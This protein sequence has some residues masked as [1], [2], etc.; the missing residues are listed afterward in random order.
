MA[1]VPPPAG[2][3]RP[4]DPPGDRLPSAASELASGIAR[5][6]TQPTGIDAAV[7]RTWITAPG[8]RHRRATGCVAYRGRERG[9]VAS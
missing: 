9:K 6:G 5:L 8:S 7:I 3:T 4:D 1:E 2:G